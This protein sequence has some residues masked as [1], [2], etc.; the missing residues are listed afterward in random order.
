VNDQSNL[1]LNNSIKGTYNLKILNSEGKIINEKAAIV[2]DAGMN[3]IALTDLFS[4]TEM[5]GG[6]YLIQ[7]SDKH[8]SRTIRFI[9]N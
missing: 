9:V 8:F 6:M 4:M 3:K 7:I 2:L 1:I 5:K